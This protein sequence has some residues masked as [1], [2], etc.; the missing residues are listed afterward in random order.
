MLNMAYPESNSAL[1]RAVVGLD[2]LLARCP[3][4]QR[5][6]AGDREASEVVARRKI[7]LL[8]YEAEPTELQ[9]RRPFAAIWPMTTG[10]SRKTLEE[11]D[12][13]G[14][15]ALLLTDVDRKGH[16]D[17]QARRA[18]GLDF[19]RW[20][21]EVVEDLLASAARHDADLAIREIRQEENDGPGRN[22]TRDAPATDSGQ[23]TGYWWV[24]YR[25]DWG[26]GG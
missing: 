23:P 1:Y 20:A 11:Y 17:N 22:A 14:T 19:L 6:V 21:G 9:R 12:A 18:S 3:S 8:E 24:M 26:H 4:F 16:H 10:W 2:A 5:R 13:M 15:V 25:I 7:E